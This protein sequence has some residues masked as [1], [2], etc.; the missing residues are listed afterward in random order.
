MQKLLIGLV[1]SILECS[2]LLGEGSFVARAE[3]IASG[4]EDDFIS[5]MEQLHK[6]EQEFNQKLQ[7]HLDDI[8]SQLKTLNWFLDNFYKNYNYTEEDAV[9]YVSN[10]INTY[11]MLK[12]TA[13]H[14]PNVK[15]K[16]FNETSAKRLEELIELLETLPQDRESD[17]AQLGLLQLYETYKMDLVPFSQSGTFK[18]EG[19]SNE[20][21]TDLRLKPETLLILS[22]LSVNRGLYDSA[23]DFLK[24]C[25]AAS[26]STDNKEAISECQEDMKVVVKKHDQLLIKKGSDGP[27]WRTHPLPIDPKKAKKFKGS[28]TKKASDPILHTTLNSTVESDQFQRLCRGEIFRSPILDRSLTCKL[29]HMGAPYL[30]IAPLKVEVISESPLVAVLR[31]FISPTEADG[32]V[33]KAGTEPSD[34]HDHDGAQRFKKKHLVS[35]TA[36]SEG[37]NRRMR[38][39]NPAFQAPLEV[40]EFGLAGAED[41]HQDVHLDHSKESGLATCQ[42]ADTT[43]V[44]Y[45]SNVEVGG[46]IAF[47]AI[48]VVSWPKKGDALFWENGNPEK[49]NPLSRY[50]VC[51][52]MWKNLWMVKTQKSW[53]E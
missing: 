44:A 34:T 31:E 23:Y 11:V 3:D 22:R 6:R 16:V 29:T 19:F 47:P 25:G 38:L 36:I 9:D 14:W 8:D 17:A 43:L 12:R 50:G 46:A 32:L 1:F 21:Q 33:R 27:N 20:V 41:V 52:V 42:N 39:V 2:S 49:P 4:T 24:A 10:P 45:L 13:V 15:A 5:G 28:P 7:E 35:T 51:P 26:P 53:Q 37:L 30:R 40:L 48:G 18:A